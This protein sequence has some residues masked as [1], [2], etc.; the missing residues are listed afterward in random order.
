MGK[1]RGGRDKWKGGEREESWNE[2]ANYFQMCMYDCFFVILSVPC[3]IG[4]KT[5][6]KGE[7]ERGEEKEERGREMVERRME[8]K[9]R[10]GRGE[11]RRKER[12]VKGER[13]RDYRD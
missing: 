10:G 2:E 4:R 11:R 6:E 13:G 1:E 12:R 7:R 8:R 5:G 9:E 3:K